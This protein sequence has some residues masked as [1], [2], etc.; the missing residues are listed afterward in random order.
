VVLYEKLTTDHIHHTYQ[1]IEV[2]APRMSFESR[3]CDAAHQAF[4]M[5]RHKGENQMEHSQYQHF[6]SRAHEGVD[7]VV[8]PVGDC[9]HVGC[10]SDQVKLTRALNEML[11][12]AMK[13][14]HQF[15]NQGA[16]TS[17]RITELE[18]LYELHEEAEAVEHNLGARDSVTQ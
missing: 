7:V 18:S 6:L 10:L 16:E 9:D 15:G 4:S 2:A 11:Y 1:V 5:L 14:I 12:Q 13:D 17:P 8:L 3:I